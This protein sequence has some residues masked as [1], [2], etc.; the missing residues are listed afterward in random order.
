MKLDFD[1]IKR[2]V[3]LPDL[4]KKYGWQ[5]AKGSS[6]TSLKMTNGSQTVVI[7]RNSND[8]LTYWDVHN[9]EIKG[10]TVF[11]FMKERIREETNKTPSLY[12]VG[13][14][15]QDFINTGE[16]DNTSFSVSSSSGY[17]KDGIAKVCNSLKP[18]KG[19]VFFRKRG[20][21]SKMLETETFKDTFF[22]NTFKKGNLTYNNICTKMVNVE[23]LV[24]ISQRNLQFKGVIGSHYN[25]I[26]ASRFDE[27]KP[28][29]S[30]YVGESM[31]DCISHYQLSKKDGENRLYISS[32]GTLTNEQILLVEKIITHNKIPQTVTIFDNDKAGHLFA[33]RL[34]NYLKEGQFMD[35]TQIRKMAD[36]TNYLKGMQNSDIKVELSESKD[37]NDDLKKN[38]SEKGYFL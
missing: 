18:Y 19:D 36:D 27:S 21:S 29:S 7:K 16:L 11:D 31:I 8:I 15:L 33:A 4:F 32:E 20:I 14:I 22:I 2:K 26:S 10:C 13:K 38:Q 1:D 17:D 12:E 35:E 23:G 5:V 34:I 25:A 3:S 37:W 24:G 6:S 9:P 30:L 28:V